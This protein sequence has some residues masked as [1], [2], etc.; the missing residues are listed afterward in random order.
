MTSTERPIRVRDLKDQ[1]G[2]EGPRPFL[3]CRECDGQY[4]ANAGDYFAAAP[5][6]VMKCCGRPMAL[7]TRKTVLTEVPA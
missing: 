5:D 4:S 3:Y 7:V 2:M 6:T 1:I